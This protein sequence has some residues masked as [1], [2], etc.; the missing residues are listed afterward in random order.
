MQLTAVQWQRYMDNTCSEAERK[1]IYTYL[2]SLTAE[3]LASLLEAGF[4]EQATTMPEAMALRLNKKL[5]QATGIILTEK[6]R[7]VLS[8]AFHRWIAA[9]SILLVAGLTLYYFLPAPS[10]A[11]QQQT[12]IASRDI[13]NTTHHVQKITLPDGSMVWLSPQSMLRVP[14]NFNRATRVLTLSGQGYFEVA[15]DA[16]KPFSVQAG[17]VQTTVLGTHFNIEAYPAE[18]HTAVSL[19]QG[20]VAVRARTAGGADSMVYLQ[21]GHK[22]VYQNDVQQFTLQPVAVEYETSWA[23]GGL[24]FD[25]LDVRDVFLRLEHRFNIKIQFDP[26]L[27][28]GKKLTAVYPK[29]D[30]SVILRNMAFVQGFNYRQQ[31]DT[32][33][34]Q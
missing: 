31:K 30:L 27:F 28:K 20:R 1:E 10:G 18:S 15:H 25:S 29:A 22:L 3:E 24:V 11:R 19:T 5:E 16:A 34:I 26:I 9:A 7:P 17:P 8:I 13:S 21:P 12:E 14:D 6:R 2:N 23:G 32:I 4:P 33:L